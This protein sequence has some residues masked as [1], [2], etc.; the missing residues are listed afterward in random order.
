MSVQTVR[1]NLMDR[2]RG[3][4]LE[5]NSRRNVVK[6]PPS[7]KPLPVHVQAA[8]RKKL[9]RLHGLNKAETNTRIL[10]LLKVNIFKS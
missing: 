10:S 9:K 3:V 1:S 8:K 2:F 5:T 7:L 4:G 6:Q